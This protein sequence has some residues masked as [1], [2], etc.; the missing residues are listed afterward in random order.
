MAFLV[1]VL[2][3]MGIDY[4]IGTYTVASL[5]VIVPALVAGWFAARKRVLAIA[6][7]RE[8]FTGEYPVRANRP[9]DDAGRED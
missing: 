1:A 5:V 2:V 8:G 3:L 6:A 7:E 9:A 4:P